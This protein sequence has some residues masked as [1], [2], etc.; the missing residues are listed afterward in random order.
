[1]PGLNLHIETM[2]YKVHLSYGLKEMMEILQL[3]PIFA[4]VSIYHV[5]IP[6]Y[7]LWPRHAGK[8]CK[9]QHQ[10]TGVPGC[11]ASLWTPHF[12]T[13]YLSAIPKDSAWQWTALRNISW[14]FLVRTDTFPHSFL[15]NKILLTTVLWYANL[16]L[17][18]LFAHVHTPELT[19]NAVSQAWCKLAELGIGPRTLTEAGDGSADPGKAHPSS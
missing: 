10:N 17:H 8:Q 4:V 11:A 15:Q 16:I 18:P 1:M 2:K 9:H 13:L 19:G 7:M 14:G 3:H 12:C 5:H 6:L